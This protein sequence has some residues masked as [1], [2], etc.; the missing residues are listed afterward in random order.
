MKNLF[1]LLGL[2]TLVLTLSFTPIDKK[3]IVIDVSHGGKDNGK[4][5]HNLSEKDITLDIAKQIK[6]VAKGSNVDIILTRDS[7]TF[8]SLKDRVDFINSQH[9]DYMISLHVNGFSND[10]TNGSE[11]FISKANKNKEASIKLADDISNSLDNTLPSRGVKEANFYILKHVECPAI[12][13]E[14]GFL[15]NKQDSSYLNSKTGQVEIAT[16]IFNSLKN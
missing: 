15:T 7:D 12:L 10:T 16:A 1:R 3:V 9:A 6:T 5:A 4:Q 14:M 2:V 11:V 13:I 8:M